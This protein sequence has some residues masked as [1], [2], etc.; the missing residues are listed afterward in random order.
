ML[1]FADHSYGRQPQYHAS[2]GSVS[3]ACRSADH[4]PWPAAFPPSPPHPP[5]Q[6]ACSR[7]SQ[8]LCDR[9]T[10]CVRSS[11]AHV[12]GLPDAAHRHSL[13][14]TQA[15]PAPAQG[16]SVHVRGLRPRGA[17]IRLAISTNAVWPS[18]VST[19]SALRSWAISRLN[20]RP[21]RPP[22][23]AS[24]GRLPVP[25]HDSGPAWLARPLLSRTCTSNTLPVLTGALKPALRSGISPPRSFCARTR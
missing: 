3:G 2:S 13:G 9:P 4:S 17:C 6:K 14:Q 1:P 23:N 7:T 15:L 16:A 11:S 10:A 18:G 5:R 19:P 24:P 20:T 25:A 8:V 21:T 12:L 22:V